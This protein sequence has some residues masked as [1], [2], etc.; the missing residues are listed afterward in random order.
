MSTPP[1]LAHPPLTAAGKLLAVLGAFD[2]AHRRLNLTRLAERAGLALTTTHR[3]AAELT[4]WGALERRP[5]D[6]YVVG[7]RL[8]NLGL[9]APVQSELGVVAAPFLHDLHAATKA[10]V[11]LAV[12]DG[13]R[14]LYVDRVSGRWSVPIVSDV[15]S[16]LP[17]HTTG[18]GKVLLAHAPAEVVERCCAD[19]VA[20][21]RWAVTDADV[22]AGQL[23]RVREQGWALTDQEMT[24]GAASLAVPVREAA[25]RV[26]AAL[27][28]V[29]APFEVGSPVQ[30]SL[31]AAL[32]VTAA[33]IE[34]CLPS[35]G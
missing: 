8:W 6:T 10:T 34:R 26:V 28:V 27:G 16:R 5:D 33:G 22:L 18:V 13:A 15:G 32:R 24:P 3:I 20:P 35:Q 30:Q 12:L 1:P 4:A 21:T 9:L 25:G 31:L 14:A 7:R 2:G 19:L 29:L 11:H 23:A 17:L